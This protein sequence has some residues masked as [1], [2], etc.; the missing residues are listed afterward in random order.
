MREPTFTE[1]RSLQEQIKA[2]PPD[3]VIAL[4]RWMVE[5]IVN[6]LLNKRMQLEKKSVDSG[7]LVPGTHCPLCGAWNPRHDYWSEKCGRPTCRCLCCL[8]GFLYDPTVTHDPFGPEIT[9]I[10]EQIGLVHWWPG[11]VNT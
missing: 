2:A 10:R 7:C 3:A 9:R 6:E 1:L 8:H 11:K 4:D 5:S